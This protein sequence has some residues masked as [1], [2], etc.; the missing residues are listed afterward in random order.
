MKQEVTIIRVS[1]ENTA[2]YVVNANVEIGET[3]GK[4]YVKINGKKIYG[5]SRVEI[6]GKGE[7]ELI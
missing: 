2:F 1:N 6:V 3:K 7:L 4:S 5:L